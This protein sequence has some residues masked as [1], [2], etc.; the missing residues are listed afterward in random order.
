MKVTFTII[1]TKR[2]S[3]RE[4]GS[5]LAHDFRSD[6]V[7]RDRE[8]GMQE[9]EASGHTV[10]KT[11]GRE[12][13]VSHTSELTLNDALHLVR[14]HLLNVPQLCKIALLAGEPVF[15]YVSLWG[16]STF[17]LEP[18]SNQQKPKKKKTFLFISSRSDE[19]KTFCTN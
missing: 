8:G 16:H 11:G 4:K 14:P 7:H 18:P 5:I 17:Q 3:L 1:T 6:G 19:L 15:K 10:S 12:R 2:S 9:Q 13:T